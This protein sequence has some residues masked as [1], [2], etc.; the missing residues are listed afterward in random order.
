MINR[1]HALVVWY[2]IVAIFSAAGCALESDEDEEDDN[3]P[4]VTEADT[5][6]SLATP[7]NLDAGTK[8]THSY[9]V[10][11]TFKSR[12]INRCL[13][14]TANGK[15]EY[16]S[17]HVVLGRVVG[18]KWSDQKIID[19]TI[20]AEVRNYAGGTCTGTATLTKLTLGQF[21]AGHDCSFNPSLS[22]SF[23]WGISFSFWPECDDRNQAGRST[24]YPAGRVYHQYNSGSPV[25]FADFVAK[26]NFGSSMK[27]RP[28]YGVFA[29]AVAFVKTSSDSF[30]ANHRSHSRKICL[31]K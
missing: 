3:D 27:Q 16:T 4:F 24:T 12:D 19:P 9:K 6:E 5:V 26:P 28:C 15:F 17:N 7:E 20:T 29:G 31:P 22:V 1:N 8:K 18:W 30:G 11:W 23:P 21:W 25:A 10:T 13:L 14:I 2:S